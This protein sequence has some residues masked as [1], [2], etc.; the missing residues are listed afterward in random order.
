MTLKNIDS[1]VAVVLTLF[2]SIQQIGSHLRVVLLRRIGSYYITVSSSRGNA[3]ITAYRNKQENVSLWKFYNLIANV[4]NNQV[5]HMKTI[6]VLVVSSKY[7]P[8]YSGSG[9]RVQRLYNRLRKKRKINVE[10][11][12]GSTE[13]PFGAV[14]VV[15]GLPVTQVS[16]SVAL[17]ETRSEGNQGLSGSLRKGLDVLVYCRDLI[18]VFMFFFQRRKVI[19]LVH[20]VGRDSVTL[21]AVTCAGL[22]RVPCLVEF[23]NQMNTAEYWSLGSLIPWFRP[24]YPELTRFVCLSPSIMETCSQSGISSNRMWLRPNP[25]DEQRFIYKKQHKN[26]LRTKL[27]KFSTDQKVLLYLAKFGELKNQSFLLEV[28]SQLPKEYC[29]ILAGPLGIKGGKGIHDVEYVASLEETITARDLSDRAILIKH[30]IESPEDFMT[31]A[32]VFVMPTLKEAFGTPAYE[33]IACGTPSVCHDLPG[34]FDQYIVNGI[35]GYTVPL[36]VE[37]WCEAITSACKIDQDVLRASSDQIVAIAGAAIIDNM[38]LRELYALAGE[39]RSERARCA[40]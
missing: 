31:L 28:I 3:L 11:L 37:S 40:A 8:E 26:R 30:F 18:A 5:R 38:Y 12:C 20:V 33:A 22:F 25:I 23:V 15:D 39:N 13:E 17:R 10:V 14:Y 1:G 2:Q 36:T 21:S 16:C 7:F 4:G 6:R 35:N 19:D 24:Q 29:L 9:L 27:T 32:D 34:V